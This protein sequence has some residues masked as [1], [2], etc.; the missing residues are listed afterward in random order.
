MRDHRDVY[1]AVSVRTRDDLAVIQDLPQGRNQ[2]GHGFPITPTFDALSYF[3][4]SWRVGYHQEV[5]AYVH[6]VTPLTYTDPSA[7]GQFD[8]VVTKLRAYKAEYAEDSSDA[9]NGRTHLTLRPLQFVVDKSNP[10]TTFFFD[11][12]Y[13][14]N[15]TDL[16]ARVVFEGSNGKQ[17]ILDYGSV[18]G[19]WVLQ[20]VHYEEILHGPLRVGALHVIADV[21]YDHYGFPAI[22]PD[23]RLA[24]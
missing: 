15:A 12:L 7:S 17:F 16:P 2:L 3:T 9:P 11:D 21:D 8:V 6:D 23:P 14:D 10:D 18:E 1:R 13:I 5:T 19:H 24:G 22:A 4:L 20:H